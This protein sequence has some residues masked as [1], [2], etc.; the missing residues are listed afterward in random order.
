MNQEKPKRQPKEQFRVVITREANEALER[1]ISQLAD[2]DSSIRITK[3][4]L[5]NYLFVRLKELL[6]EADRGGYPRDLL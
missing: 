6:D 4:E 1:F 3:S 2:D 5:A